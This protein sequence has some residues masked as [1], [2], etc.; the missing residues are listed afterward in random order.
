MEAPYACPRGGSEVRRLTAARPSRA[1]GRGPGARRPARALA[2]HYVPLPPPFRL[3]P[4]PTAIAASPLAPPAPADAGRPPAAIVEAPARRAAKAIVLA[5]A[6]EGSGADAGPPTGVSLST[7][8]FTPTDTGRP[9]GATAGKAAYGD[10]GGSCEDWPP[11]SSI[12]TGRSHARS[13]Q[14]RRH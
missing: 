13:D 9:P 7:G 3:A 14:R 4:S 12:T 10:H 11:G 8:V 6:I 1:R 2:A 5:I